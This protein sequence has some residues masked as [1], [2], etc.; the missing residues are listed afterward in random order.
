[1]KSNNRRQILRRKAG[2]NQGWQCYYCQQPMWET[3]PKI[4]SARYRVSRRAALLFRCTAE[5]LVARCDGGRDTE[6]NI[7]AACHYCNRT[8]HRKKGPK[9]AVSYGKFVRSRM[10]QGRWHPV[11]LTHQTCEADTDSSADV[12][13][14]HTKLA[15]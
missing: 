1:M 3:N 15:G 10:K 12:V 13:L 8:R 2:K 14:L 5:H 7:V 4:F 11:R 6:E 9:D